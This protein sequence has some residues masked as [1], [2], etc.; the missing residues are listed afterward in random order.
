MF[1]KAVKVKNK[2]YPSKDFSTVVGRALR[3]AGRVA[4]KTA[5]IYGTPIYVWR[6]G[7]V[8]RRNL[9]S[10]GRREAAPRDVLELKTGN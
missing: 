9:E 6:D 10:A 2:K 8:G 5:R 7:K 4:R 1:R 3:R